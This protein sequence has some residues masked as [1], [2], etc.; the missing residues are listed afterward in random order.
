LARSFDDAH[1]ALARHVVGG[2]EAHVLMGSAVCRELDLE[3]ERL[4]VNRRAAR[5]NAAACGATLHEQNIKK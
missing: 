2:S 4:P 5:R 1:A 3:G